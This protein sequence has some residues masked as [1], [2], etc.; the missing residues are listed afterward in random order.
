MSCIICGNPKFDNAH[1]KSRGSGGTNDYWNILRLCRHHH[2][3]QHS[4]GWRRFSGM[5]P[6]IADTLDKYGWE[7]T[8]WG[9]LV[10][11]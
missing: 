3:L 2:R 8:P 11:K 7:F 9:K 5:Y 10:R 1:I 4:Y 6:V